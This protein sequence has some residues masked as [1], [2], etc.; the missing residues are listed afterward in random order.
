[1]ENTCHQNA[2]CDWVESEMRNKCVCNPG[3]EGDGYECVEHEVSCLIVSVHQ[4]ENHCHGIGSIFFETFRQENICHENASCVYEEMIGK[5]VCKCDEKFVGDGRNCQL[6]PEC[7][8]SSDCTEN[9]Y[10]SNGL[11]VCN[12]GYKRNPGSDVYVEIKCFT[13]FCYSLFSLLVFVVVYWPAIVAEHCVRKMRFAC[14]TACRTFNIAAAPPV[15][16][17]MAWTAA[18]WFRL[19]AMWRTIVD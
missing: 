4:T 1:M 7:E 13:P 18:N 6:E 12:E 15:L 9:S 16:Q 2:K 3:Y 19:H 17:A 10:C 8:L 5:S 11:C 14:M